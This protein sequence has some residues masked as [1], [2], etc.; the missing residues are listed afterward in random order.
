MKKLAPS[1]VTIGEDI[2]FKES[3]WD[4]LTMEDEEEITGRYLSDFLLNFNSSETKS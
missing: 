2:P 3:H 4:R 1:V